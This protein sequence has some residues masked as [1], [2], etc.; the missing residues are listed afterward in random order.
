MTSLTALIDDVA[1]VDLNDF[2]GIRRELTDTRE[3][4]R[5]LPVGSTAL[6][7]VGTARSHT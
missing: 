2:D 7:V 1:L 6:M 3:G 5:L 4:H